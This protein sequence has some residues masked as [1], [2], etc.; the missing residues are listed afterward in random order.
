VRWNAGRLV[1]PH[2]NPSINWTT[3]QVIIC[4]DDQPLPG[5]VGS[6]TSSNDCKMKSVRNEAEDF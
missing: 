3:D 4:P 5:T 1:E 6:S 2:K